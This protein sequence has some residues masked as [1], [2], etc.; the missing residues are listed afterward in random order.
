MPADTVPQFHAQLTKS[1]V[2]GPVAELKNSATGFFLS[3][4]IIKKKNAVKTEG[5]SAKMSA[6]N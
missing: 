5:A 6:T 1:A 2:K 4:E 3:T